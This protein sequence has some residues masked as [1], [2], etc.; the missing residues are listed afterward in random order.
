MDE[1]MEE[2]DPFEFILGA[3]RSARPFARETTSVH[4]CSY[5]S[6]L[7]ETTEYLPII[8]G[9]VA[10]V[11]DQ[12]QRRIDNEVADHNRRL[13]SVYQRSEKCLCKD[14]AVGEDHE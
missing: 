14:P 10:M 12:E 9:M 7:F 8:V 3:Y 11:S 2:R 5:C 6:G 1:N 13:A 4:R